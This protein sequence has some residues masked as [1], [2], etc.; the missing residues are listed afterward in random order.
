M[1][2]QPGVQANRTTERIKMSTACIFGLG[3]V[4]SNG[5]IV[6]AFNHGLN[7]SVKEKSKFLANKLMNIIVID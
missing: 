2:L 5:M 7:R 6:N 4:I 1:N 3:L